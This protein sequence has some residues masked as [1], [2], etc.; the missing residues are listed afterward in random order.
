M[1]LK[2]GTKM[3]LGYGL[4]LAMLGVVLLSGLSGLSRVEETYETQVLRIAENSRIA[5]EVAWHVMTQSFAVAAFITT[6]DGAY[7]AMFEE[8]EAGARAA[9]DQL[10]ANSVSDRALELID[11]VAALHAEYSR[12]ARP[13]FDSF[14]SMSGNQ[15]FQLVSRLDLLRTD[16]LDTVD[17]LLEYQAGRRAE[18]QALVDEGSAQ[19]RR[20]MV[21]FALVS[22]II[23]A[24][25]A[26]TVTRSVAGPARAVAEAADRLAEGDLTLETLQVKTRDEVG[27]MANAFNRMV[28]NFRTMMLSIRETSAEL[29]ESGRTLREMTETS[30]EAM[31]QIV[32]AINQVSDG[33]VQQ[34]S[35]SHTSAEAADQL[36][37]A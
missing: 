15:F 20:L 7:R 37:K 29:M 9:L 30:A 8:A 18:Q 6:D 21:L 2:I 34:A 17:E 31:S 28:Q 19:A 11:W 16:L 13:L 36:R 10:R 12:E 5:Q 3:A 23:G 22:L 1:R 27:D 14:A 35:H 33:A 32:A 26:V 24:V 25:A 4:V